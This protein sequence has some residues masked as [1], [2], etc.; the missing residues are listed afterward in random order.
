M[1]KSLREVY[2]LYDSLY[3]PAPSDSEVSY[4]GWSVLDSQWLLPAY[5][6][7]GI[8]YKLFRLDP[9]EAFAYDIARI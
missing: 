3:T 8:G 5:P 6:D 2:D 4:V 9:S 1:R 7:Y